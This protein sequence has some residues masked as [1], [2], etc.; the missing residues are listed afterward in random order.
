MATLHPIE[1]FTVPSDAIF[2]SGCRLEGSFYGSDGYRAARALFRSGFDLHNVGAHAN[3]FNPP[4]FKRAYVDDEQ[5]GVPYLTGSALLEARPVK[6]AFLSRTLTSC[7]DELSVREGMVLIS[8][9]GSIGRTILATRD[10]DGWVSTNNL[11]RV[12]SNDLRAFSQEFFYTYFVT[13]VGEYLLTR[14]TYGS[15]VEHIEPAHVRQTPFP[16]LPRLLREKLTEMIQRVNVLR[17]E[18]NRLLTTA[19]A[20]V[21]RQCGL[22]RL[23]DLCSPGSESSLSKAPVYTAAS[24]SVMS[25]ENTF[26]AIRLDATYYDPIAEKLRAVIL[27]SGGTVLMSVLRGVRNSKLRKRIYVDDPSAGVPMIGGKQLVQVRPA[28]VSYLSRILTRDVEEETVRAGWT[29]ISCGGTLGRTL[30]VHR[31]FEGWAV[32][33]D[34]MRLLPASSE[35]WPGYLFAFAA[36]PYGQ[37]QLAQRGYGSV[38]PRLRDFQ[39]NSIAIAIPTDK[40]KQIHELVV[41]AFDKRADALALEDDA[42][43]LFETAIEE[44][45]ETTEAKWGREY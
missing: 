9:S 18:A 11:I 32:S 2:Q 21:Q 19:E 39:F 29:L 41:R 26:G 1:A 25:A 4:I 37:V 36:S 16:V 22:P 35:I 20:E 15:V 44:G 43:R 27:A 3:V 24:T 34:V 14:N 45:K 6:D 12:L 7:L 33:Q 38:I 28:D 10:I 8:D 30:F 13:S 40:G 17:V 23:E 5:H 42:I 31:N